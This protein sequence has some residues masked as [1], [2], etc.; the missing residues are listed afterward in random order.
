MKSFLLKNVFVAGFAL[1]VGFVASCSDDG[2]SASVEESVLAFEQDGNLD[3]MVKVKASGW[4]TFLGTD[5]E[6]AKASDKP[7][8]KV[9]FDYDFYLG[10]SEVTCGEFNKLMKPE[11]GLKTDCDD[12]ELP[13]TNVSY[14]DAVL[15]ANARS[16]DE[17]KDTAY[18][19]TGAKFD[20]SHNCIGLEKLFFSASVDAYRLPSEA[21]W[22]LVASQNWNAENAWHNGNSDYERH[23]VCEKKSS[24]QVFCD[25]AGN[26]MEWV[27]DWLGTL[28]DTVITDY[29]GAPDGGSIGERVVKGGSYTNELSSI[30]YYS[31][32]DV[33]TVTSATKAAYVGFRLA[34]GKVD[35]A[36]WM[37]GRGSA[38]GN[39]VSILTSVS[40]MKKLL[41]TYRSK[42][43]FRNDMTGNI[44][45]VNFGGGSLS[46]FEIQD[47]L[48]CFHPEISPDGQWVAFS[49]KF[50]GI[51]GKSSL[52]VRNLNASGSNLVRLDVESAAIPRWRVLEGGDTAIVYVNDAGSNKED[53]S[54]KNN[55]TWQVP[56]AKGKFGKPEKLFDGNFHGGVSAD[57]KLAVTGAQLLRVSD[58]GEETLWY[59]GEQACNVS[60]AP[61]DKQTLFLDFGG[62]S[63]REFA[64]DKYGVH[65]RLLIADSA[66]KLI[67]SVAAPKGYSFDHS[68][69]NVGDASAHM[70]VATLSNVD[71]VHSKIVLVNLADSSVTELA[72]GEEVWHP[73]LWV[74]THNAVDNKD[75]DLDS[76]GVYFTEG[77]D[78]VHEVLRIKMGMLWQ[79]RDSIEILAV[80]SSRVEDGIIPNKMKSGYCLNMGH[81][82]NDFNASLYIARNYGLNHMP[83]LKTVVVSL[84]L[85]LWQNKTAFSDE[86]FY[87]APGYIYDARHDFWKDA[88]PEG[89]IDAVA[90]AYPAA[91]E[92]TERYTASLG[93][94]SNG[95]LEW[96][97]PLVE[98]DSSWAEKDESIVPWQLDLLET[99]IVDALERGINVV[100]LLF[101]QNPAYVNTGSWGRYGPTRTTAKKILESLTDLSKKYG[102]FIVMDENKMGA[103][104]YDDTM[105]LNTDHLSNEGASRVTERLDTLLKKMVSEN[106]D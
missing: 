31:R 86:L 57:G 44:A 37:D 48:D 23:P 18:T 101:P 20:D 67:N 1:T 41:G 99:F 73:S 95:A 105:A 97:E 32:G 4:N 71:G 27:N 7:K 69:W 26:A 74:G 28:Q 63:G 38:S 68:E 22:V 62:K 3:G 35:H 42:L 106:S 83:K 14:Y 25:M 56:F 30:N 53:G 80:G 36:T 2:S 11:T 77:G 17:G 15:Y 8:M 6:N 10:M 98:T 85:D 90:N 79:K 65:E 47:S 102:N 16:K 100:G 58:N 72:M 45:F 29:M 52:Y 75:L 33:Y 39:R 103:H 84:D 92:P 76:A 55:S 59:D 96:G 34:F 61:K 50:E 87:G 40:E 82:G 70:V 13:V 5:A 43:A 60:L 46:V 81:P 88:I 78:W 9:A 66:G 64:G 54:F 12:S 93:Y 89:F 21:E 24:G 49:T 51:S 91:P 104:D 19:Y 94:N